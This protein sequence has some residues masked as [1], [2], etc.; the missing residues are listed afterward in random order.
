MSA[1]RA[2]SL[3]CALTAAFAFGV[4]FGLS[5]SAC[6]QQAA[7][8]LSREN[9]CRALDHTWIDL[10]KGDGECLSPAMLAELGVK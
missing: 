6:R 4:V 3:I 2:A 10:G 7:G 1:T 9:V 8:V 5:A